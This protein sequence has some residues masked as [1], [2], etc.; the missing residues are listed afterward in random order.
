MWGNQLGSLIKERNKDL[1]ACALGLLLDHWYLSGY[2][3]LV[4]DFWLVT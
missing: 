4:A 2:R 1:S 3:L